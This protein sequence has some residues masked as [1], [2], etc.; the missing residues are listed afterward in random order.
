M[1]AEET[2]HASK[3]KTGHALDAQ[4]FQM[5]EDIA[6]ELD[7]AAI[8]PIHFDLAVELRKRLTS[9]GQEVEELAGHIIL[10]PLLVAR[11]I[12]LACARNGGKAASVTYRLND[13]IAH[14]GAEKARKFA[15][16]VCNNQLLRCKRMAEFADLSKTLWEHSRHA[17]CAA[18]VISKRFTR[19]DPREAMVAGLIHDLGA[20][21]LLYRATQ[22][23]EL[24]IRPDSVRHLISHWHESIGHALFVALG[25]P[26]PLLDAIRDHDQPRLA[27]HPPR[28]LAEVVYLGNLL[29]C[30]KYGWKPREN[31]EDPFQTDVQLAPYRELAE[32]IEDRA[33]CLGGI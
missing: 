7:G 28:N 12:G 33:T 6:R 17:A 16:A 13:A 22:Y 3:A 21:Y 29:A 5:L 32:E 15:L 18:Y 30:G 10:D 31:A 9:P 1:S 4:R 19:I 23:D 26:E 14:I 2:S 8:F 11:L 27:P 25:L 24:R 20:F